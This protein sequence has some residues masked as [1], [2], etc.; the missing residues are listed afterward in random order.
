MRHFDLKTIQILETNYSW[1][2]YYP[3]LLVSEAIQK[4]KGRPIFGRDGI[5]RTTCF[6]YIDKSD[7]VVAYTGL[8]WDTGTA[9]EVEYAIRQDKPILAW[10]D[11][12]VTYGET[13]GRNIV[14]DGKD[15]NKLYVR[16]M[17]F[18]A[19]DVVFDRYIELSKLYD[20]GLKEEDL[21]QEIDKQ[22]RTILNLK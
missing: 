22:A 10:S 6:R 20:A 17:P 2:V 19:M 13:I 7:V 14:I 8:I 1:S 15:I 21:A 4:N 9:R 16:T 5:I 3:L 12:S 11:S 18:N